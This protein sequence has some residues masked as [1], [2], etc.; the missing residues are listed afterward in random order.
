MLSSLV[1]D[2]VFNQPVL[3]SVLVS[4]VSDSISLVLAKVG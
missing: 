2:V 1:K 3:A 4:S